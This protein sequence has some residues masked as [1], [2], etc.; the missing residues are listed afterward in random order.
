[1]ASV[2]GKRAD[3]KHDKRVDAKSYVMG[4][5]WRFLPR[6]GVGQRADRRA[7]RVAGLRPTTRKNF[8][9]GGSTGAKHVP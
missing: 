2:N 1:M 6:S 5:G 7:R 8:R 4:I 3:A 9:R